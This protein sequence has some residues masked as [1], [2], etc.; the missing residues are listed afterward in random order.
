MLV[1]AVPTAVMVL[2]GVF[3]LPSFVPEAVALSTYQTIPLSE[4]ERLA[5]AVVAVGV[6]PVLDEIVYVQVADVAETFG[7]KM[8]RPAP[9]NV[10]SVPPTEQLA[11]VTETPPA[12]KAPFRSVVAEETAGVAGAPATPVT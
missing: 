4:N 2:N 6:P 3:D 1:E 5:V 8:K 12:G 7:V 11:A 9:S 10:V